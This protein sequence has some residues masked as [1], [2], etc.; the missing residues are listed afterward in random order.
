[1]KERAA[2]EKWKHNLR[3]PYAFNLLETVVASQI[4]MGL[5]FDVRPSPHFA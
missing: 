5:T 2:A 4:D 1:V 3:P